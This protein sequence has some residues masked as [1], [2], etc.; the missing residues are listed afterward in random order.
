MRRGLALLAIAAGLHACAHLPVGTDG[1][2]FE[3]R[4]ARLESH[5]DVQIRGRLAVATG[6]RGFQGSF[7]WQ[8]GADALN[9]LV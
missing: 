5:D 9:L 1:V 6:E 2:S 3:E 4:R 7:Q 8:Q